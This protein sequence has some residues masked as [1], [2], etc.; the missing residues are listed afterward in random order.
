MTGYHLLSEF[1]QAM[2]PRNEHTINVQSVYSFGE[3]GLLLFGVA[4]AFA[5]TLQRERTPF[6]IGAL[7]GAAFLLGIACFT[8]GFGN[9]VLVSAFQSLAAAATVDADKFIG[10]VG[11]A[12]T[13]LL[14]GWTCALVGATLIFLASL[15]H[16]RDETS[17]PLKLTGSF[18][19]ALVSCII[20]LMA[21]AYGGFSIR[22]LAS[23]LGEPP[24]Y[25]PA[26]IASGTSGMLLARFMTVIGIA[27]SAVAS[28]LMAVATKPRPNKIDQRV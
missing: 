28:M 15:K 20:F 11:G 5:A 21:I 14:I 7:R 12:K 1:G 27:A 18:W 13:P 10:R 23:A 4:L 19:F 9:W 17:E 24:P 6:T 26:E 22:A 3:L 16:S 25:D 2:D 8:I